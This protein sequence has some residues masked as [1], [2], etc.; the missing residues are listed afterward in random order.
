M[1]HFITFGTHGIYNDFARQLA[2][3][4]LAA[5][6]DTATVYD[7]TDLDPAFRESHRDVLALP[8]G[9][10]AWCWKSY[11]I[12]KR[13]SELEEGDVV[14][15]CDSLY[16]FKRDFRE[17]AEDWLK[18][19]DLVLFENKPSEPSY[20]ERH[21]T[22]YEA[23]CI[24]GAD[25]EVHGQTSQCWG[26]FLML[27]KTPE[28]VRFIQEWY[29]RCANV[30]LMSDE[31]SVLGEELPGFIEPRQDQMVLSLSWQRTC[32]RSFRCSVVDGTGEEVTEEE[33]QNEESEQKEA[34]ELIRMRKVRILPKKYQKRML[35]DWRHAARY[36]YNKAVFLMNETASFNKM[37]LR[38]M[39]TPAEVNGDKPHLLKTPKDVRAAAVFEAAKNAKACFSN[40]E[41]GNITG[42]RL[43]FKTRKRED[44]KGWC[45]GIA[46][47]AIKRRGDRTLIIYGDYCPWE[48][49][50]LG[51]IGEITKDCQ[52]QFDGAKYYLLV[53]YSKAHPA[54]VKGNARSLI[55]ETR[56]AVIALDPG[57]R[58]FLTAYSP[59]EAY[60]LGDGCAQRLFSLAIT[61][62]RLL[63]FEKRIPK[64]HRK[65][66]RA[67]RLRII[68]TRRKIAHLRDE[69]HY[70]V[71]D[72]LTRKA[73]II[74][75]PTFET[76]EMVRRF[77]WRIGS[78][79]VRQMSFLSH[80]KFTQRLIAKAAGRGVRVLIVS[81]HYTSKT[82]G[83]CGEVKQNLEGLSNTPV[84]QLD[85]GKS[86]AYIGPLRKN[87]VDAEKKVDFDGQSVSVPLDVFGVGRDQL[88]AFGVSA[89]KQNQMFQKW[90]TLPKN[91]QEAYTQSWDSLDKN[92]ST[93]LQGFLQGMIDALS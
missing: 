80:Y 61:L 47:T 91:Q 21:W 67:V 16:A 50:T 76:S 45:L 7:E 92:D 71:A 35:N 19:Q 37:Y 56:E 81:E 53:P 15:Y 48:F 74:L 55:N 42:F 77:Q 32:S 72:F 41:R 79:S 65:K 66:R 57:V 52:L 83:R 70:K 18:T 59:S 3:S 31:R 60:K 75:L 5:G 28:T 12:L 38:D 29:D 62:D 63:A 26:G 10:G 46:K 44:S 13:L 49:E 22:K 11:C 39:I 51:A 14:T 27:R 64:D 84:I 2:K 40:R 23:F 30:R 73:K 9:F 36:S 68:K 69:M 24:L 8:R 34:E 4:A 1:M 6:F 43:S 87:V 17:A 33:K 88:T 54:K 78:K 58:T 89:E 20:K 93:A 82:C 25:P 85:D 86:Q 90:R